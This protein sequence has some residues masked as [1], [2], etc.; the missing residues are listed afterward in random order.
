MSVVTGSK[1][2][3]AGIGKINYEGPQSDNP[4]AYRWYDENKIVAGKK[5]E[6]L[7]SLCLRLLAQLLR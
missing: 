4:L 7:A 5:N 3:F 2:F 1:E 6:R